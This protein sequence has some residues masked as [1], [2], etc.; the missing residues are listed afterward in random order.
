MS[1]AT[2]LNRLK[3]R[4]LD[5]EDFDEEIRAHLAIATDE[6]MGDGADRQTAHYAALK[7]FGNL[8]LNT[9]RRT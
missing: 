5:D 7:D 9:A 1:I 8:T 3:R 6:R 2:W 4:R